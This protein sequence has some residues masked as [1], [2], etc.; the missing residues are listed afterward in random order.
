MDP[1]V[2]PADIP[3]W[4]WIL[5]AAAAG[6]FANKVWPT[7][8]RRLESAEKNETSQ[9]ERFLKA[10]EQAAEALQK[11]STSLDLFSRNTVA[12][13]FEIAELRREVRQQQRAADHPTPTETET[14]QRML[15]QPPNK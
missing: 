9:D 2:I 6:F 7:L 14:L 3:Q 15:G 13:T 1:S 5:V 8:E 10:Y 4:L 11:I 12:L